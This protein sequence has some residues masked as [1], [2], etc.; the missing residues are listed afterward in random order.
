MARPAAPKRENVRS[1]IKWDKDDIS[2]RRGFRF[3]GTSLSNKVN[4]RAGT[5]TAPQA[6]IRSLGASDH[7][8]QRWSF[9]AAHQAVLV[10]YLY[11]SS[12]GFQ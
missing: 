8:S 2:V 7:A 1:A 6:P 3:A 4:V 10:V 11:R 9:T 5:N 12:S